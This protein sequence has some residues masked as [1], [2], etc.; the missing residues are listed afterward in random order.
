MKKKSME[1]KQELEEPEATKLQIQEY[2]FD[3][4]N[5]N[6]N[7]CKEDWLGSCRERDDK[8]FKEIAELYNE[9]M[10]LPYPTWR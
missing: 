7:A 6:R 4:K 3:G 8:T 10:Q 9:A 5:P 1:K 2:V